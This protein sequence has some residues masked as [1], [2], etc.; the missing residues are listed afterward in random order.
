MVDPTSQRPSQR[1]PGRATRAHRVVIL[2]GGAGGVSVAARLLREKPGLDVAII[3]PSEEHHYQ[4]GWTLVGGGEMRRRDTVRAQRSVLPRAAEWIRASAAAIDPDSRRIELEDGTSVEYEL[5]VVAVGIRCRWEAIPGLPET[6]GRD[7]VCS[8]YSGEHVERTWEFIQGLSGGRAV[9]THP[10][11]PIKC[12][13]APQKIMYLAADHWRRRRVLE[14]TEIRFGIA[15]PKIFGAAHYV[16]PLERVAADYGIGVLYRHDLREI[17][18]AAR[19]AVFHDLDA[20]TEVV[21]PYDL[22]HVTPPMGPPA[23]IAESPLAGEG[24]W[25]AV[26]RETCRHIRYPDVFSLGD[27]SSLPTSKTAAAI[28][29]QAPV[30]VTNLLA[31]LE[32]RT[33]HAAYDG[34]TSCPLVTGYGRLILAEFD[35][36]GNPQETFPFDQAKPRWTMYQL[37]KRLLPPLYWHGM[38]KGRC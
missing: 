11:T 4:P 12:G 9:F 16:H 37:K 19:E 7:G 31:A 26:D 25:V 17:R 33:G 13:G 36:D 23:F 8:N 2:G 18:P 14:E 35:Y 22:L 21:L 3:E 27:V 24:G 29:K 1:T 6:L 30:V 32:E 28:R 15:T 20:E 38:L 5:L 34:Y 10:A